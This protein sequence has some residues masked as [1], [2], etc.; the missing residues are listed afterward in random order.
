MVYDRV[1]LRG[2]VP[3]AIFRMDLQIIEGTPRHQSVTKQ[4]SVYN[5]ESLISFI[6]N[7]RRNTPVRVEDLTQAE[8]GLE[9]LRNAR[10]SNDACLRPDPRFI[11]G[12]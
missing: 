7:I 11:E 3:V 10:E 12:R 2:D 5:E 6:S 9:M 1:E 8:W 4:E